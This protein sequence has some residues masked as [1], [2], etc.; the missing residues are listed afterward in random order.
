MD[1]ALLVTR[2]LKGEHRAYEALV[3][4]YQ[5]AVFGLAFSYVH[6][7]QDAEDLVQDAFIRGY[8][9]LEILDHPARF[10]SWL[11]SVVK[12]PVSTKYERRSRGSCCN[13]RMVE[14]MAR[15]PQAGD[16]ILRFQGQDALQESVHWSTRGPVDP[17]HR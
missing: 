13:Y 8:L 2:S 9:R 17:A 16:N 12:E 4:K 7:E 3:R 11:K 10:G 6:N 15:K 5:N 14:L 1:D